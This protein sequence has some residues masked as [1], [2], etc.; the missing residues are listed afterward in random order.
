MKKNESKR[1]FNF[2]FAFLLLNLA[3]ITAVQAQNKITTPKEQFGF[4]IG[5]DYHLINYTEI[6]NYW[7]K[8]NVESDRMK[9]VD[10]GPTAE[11]RR[12][13]MAIITSPE[14]LKKLDHYREISAKLALAKGLTDDNAK[15]LSIE[16]KAVVWIDGGLHA[17]EVAGSQQLMQLAYNMVSKNDVETLRILDDV[18][19]LAVFANPDGLE[20]VADWY[21]RKDNEKDRSYNNLPRLYQK[22]IGHDNNR[23]SYMVTQ[24]ETEN[25]ARVMY[26][27]WYPQLMYNHHQTGPNGAI[28]FVPPFRDPVNYYFDP[29]LIIGIQSLGTAMH[30]R[31]IA[32]GLP[33][34][35]MRSKANYSTWFNGNLRTTGY[36]HNQIGMLTE[37]KGTPAPL[38]LEL[39]PEELLLGTDMPFPVTPRML[40]FKD[41]I[42]YSISMD[43]AVLD[44]ASRNREPILYNRYLMGKNNI[45]KGSGD[46]WTIRPKIV[47]EVSKELKADPKLKELLSATGRRR[48]GAPMKYYDLF[49][50][51]ENRDPRA[52]IVSADQIDFATATKF[53]NTFIKNGVDVLQATADFKVNGKTYPVGS[54][55]FKTDQAFRPHILDLFEPQDHPND[56][57]YPG[58]P[59]VAPYDNAGYTLAYQMGIEF[60]R[61]MEGIEG[62][63]EKIEGL[64]TPLPGKVTNAK[65]ATGFLLSH[66]INDAAIVTNRLLKSKHQIFWL[67]NPIEV[68]GKTYP[69]GTIYIKAKSSSLKIIEEMANQLGINFEGTMKEPISSALEL[70]SPRI[71]LWDTYGGSMSSGW[72]R[73]I[74]EQY[75]FPFDVVYPKALDAGDLNKK[76]DV[77]VF[78]SGAIPS[79][80]ARTASFGR[81]QLNDSTIPEEYRS[82]LGQIT[83]AKTIPQLISFLNNGG[84]IIAIGSSTN[85]AGHLKL[86]MSNH[87][88]DK[89]GNSLKP[90]VYYIPATIL[91]VR[92]DNKQPIAYGMNE[93]VNIFFDESPVFRFKPEADKKGVKSIAWFDSDK[94][95]TSGWAWGQD[96]L[97]GGV[98]IAE[99]KVGKG[100]LY[101][102]GPEIL[103][104]AQSHGTFKLFFN[105]L[106]LSTSKSTTLK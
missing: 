106:F 32:D 52:Y 31:L 36:F 37:I 1:V 67:T 20:L 16:G 51:P 71:A 41:A 60:E 23:D 33:G 98:A 96:R 43:M 49:K 74:M 62:P 42:Q 58:G 50:K 59:P 9:L 22:Y 75:E 11:G 53:V 56:F 102:F 64:A 89:D 100:N 34:S 35:A 76:Y 19:L 81:G 99:A 39:Y 55:I 91:Q 48:P 21:M 97:Y 5:D 68:N 88:V 29:L 15:A 92:M 12:Q 18:I 44:Y 85:L 10:I 46:S 90:E 86:P 84:S 57:Q 79:G 93:R 47:E 63:F 70:S 87:M 26:K 40:Y 77:I 65:N 13:F 30:S 3:L 27:E 69:V 28:V 38:E 17:T 73:W 4:N 101:L 83:P 103:Y 78:V 14:N 6:V 80:E 24:P 2:L 61:I 105:G 72:T 7:E 45:Q 94:P 8:L 104:R 54:Y 25:M 95:L 82:W 66:Q